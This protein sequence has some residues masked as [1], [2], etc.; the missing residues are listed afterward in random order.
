M[1]VPVPILFLGTYDLAF[2]VHD[3]TIVVLGFFWLYV[4]WH[5]LV[6]TVSCDAR[7]SNFFVIEHSTTIRC[8]ISPVLV[9]S[10]LISFKHLIKSNYSTVIIL[11][12]VV[13]GHTSAHYILWY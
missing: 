4:I 1:D 10:L 2:F 7:F 6:M 3:R 8:H 12:R 13:T 11:F 9:L 5:S